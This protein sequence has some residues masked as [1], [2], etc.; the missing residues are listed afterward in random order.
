MTRHE[1][2][3]EVRAYGGRFFHFAKQ[4]D[5]SYG[6]PE[7]PLPQLVS[8]IGAGQIGGKARGLLFVLH[9]MERG[10]TVP[11]FQHLVRFPRSTVLATQLFDDFME[12]N[13]LDEVVQAGCESPIRLAEIRTRFL[14]ASFPRR[15]ES[16]LR[17]LL[18]I[19]L[20]PLVVRS[21]SV[22]EDDPDHSFAGIYLSEFLPN[23]GSDE[24]RLSRLIDAVKDV[25]AST[26]GPNARAYRKRHKLAWQNEKMAILIQDMVGRQYP[27][28]LFYPLVAGVSF[29]RN[30]YPWTPAL[31]TE[32]GTVRLVV[33]TGTRA[34][35]RE[36]ARVFSI[37][38]PGLRPEGHDVRT[39]VRNSQETVDVLDLRAGRL[40]QRNLRDLENPLLA[41]ICSIA[42]DDGTL[43]TP[44]SAVLNAASSDRLVASFDRLISGTQIMP[45]TPLLRALMEY[46]E[47]LLGL[48]VDV[49][50]A[51]DFPAPDDAASSPQFYV[52]QVRPLGARREHRRVRIPSFSQD[53]ILLECH[54]VLGNG[55][56]RGLQHVVY[57]DPS[58]YRHDQAY[59][60]ART[61]GR[62]NESLDEQPYILIGPGRWASSNPQLGVPVQ[63]GEII[64]AAV[65][66]EMST[67]GFSP[68]LSYGTHFYA[69][70]VASEV[71]YLPFYESEGDWLHRELLEQQE[72]ERYGDCIAHYV[73]S[74]GLKAYV[75]GAGRRG[76]IA[77]SSKG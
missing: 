24:E 66:V 76:V 36:Y 14:A 17:D 53:R 20:G 34:V 43:R 22:M 74:R 1:R 3:K 29:S 4:L 42:H 13:D 18:G 7:G 41:K 44:S 23:H 56:R 68:E 27:H 62:I 9:E 46:L 38:R 39:I 30:Y 37:A 5:G 55:I 65:I 45:F 40:A 64:G 67:E 72:A 6:I 69:D 11:E 47:S 8:V 33:G 12:A 10:S 15:W 59:E 50:F 35:G 57:V 71:L 49:E 54:H 75:D 77:L 73:V 63:Y 28:D 21:S 26:F 16:A 52:L 61:V 19:H 2:Q 51:V 58:K 32:D 48:P 70:M 25:Y 60:I 31:S